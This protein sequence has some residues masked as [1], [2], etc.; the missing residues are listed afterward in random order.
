MGK[1]AKRRAPAREETQTTPEEDRGS[2]LQPPE[3]DG[4]GQ[5]ST[6][7]EPP[8]PGGPQDAP[9]RPK[10][11][12][13]PPGQATADSNRPS[14][15][16]DLSS[17]SSE[18]AEET[19]S[20]TRERKSLKGAK[21]KQKE[22]KKAAKK[23][24]KPPKAKEEKPGDGAP[25]ELKKRLDELKKAARDLGVDD[26][27]LATNVALLQAPKKKSSKK[28]KAKMSAEVAEKLKAD[29]EAQAKRSRKKEEDRLAA[30]EKD[31]RET[32]EQGWREEQLQETQEQIRAILDHHALSGQQ[33]KAVIDWKNYLE[34]GKLPSPAMCAAPNPSPTQPS[35]VK[36]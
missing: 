28:D 18:N 4:P 1:K 21:Q 29:M 12:S 26:A 17:D 2:S 10:R 34:C 32:L 24:R 23:G 19:P 14:R 35:N 36:C 30:I 13:A 33:E 8:T 6:L 16:S 22:A 31:K 5:G 11:Q 15:N 7:P 20:E 27:L 3:G 25:G 9:K